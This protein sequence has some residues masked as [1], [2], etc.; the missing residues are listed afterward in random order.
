MLPG[1]PRLIETYEDWRRWL[2]HERRASP[3][4][5]DAYAADVA[6]FLR[7]LAEHIGRAPDLSDLAS[8][9]H[10]DF[11]AWLARRMTAGKARTSTA[12]ALSGVRSYF[13]YLD[14]TGL[15]HNA[16]LGA[17]RGPRLPRSVPKALSVEQ[18]VDV[19]SAA[20]ELQPT[21]WVGKRDT[22]VFSLLYGC[23]L[24]IGEALGLD[25]RDFPGAGAREG[26][27]L[28]ITG[29]GGK[30]RVVPLLPVVASAIADYVAACPF[31]LDPGGPLFVGVRGKRLGPRVVQGQMRKL[32]VW[33]GLPPEATPH[34]LRHSFATHLLAAG[35]DLRTIQE[36][37]GHASLAT[38]Q[39]YTAVDAAHLLE[40]YRAAHPRAR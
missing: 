22:A 35:G 20:T 32:K 34:A 15:V 3:H 26:R 9:G 37:L 4:T 11:R 24:R 17:M 39:R 21:D 29:K 16:T 14:L 8:L 1:H 40:V 19:P 2:R 38:T 30:Q 13:R 23:G 33:L 6:G 12:R 5:R 31:Q 7:F 18:A 36:L 10:R 27:S 28:V 25:R